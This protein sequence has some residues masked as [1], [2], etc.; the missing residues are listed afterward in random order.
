M[1]RVGITDDDVKRI[2]KHRFLAQFEWYADDVPLRVSRPV[3]EQVDLPPA[4]SM[5]AI[6]WFKAQE[7]GRR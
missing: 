3:L 7:K 4:P 5:H 1:K 2:N 6:D